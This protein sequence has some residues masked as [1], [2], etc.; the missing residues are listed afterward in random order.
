MNDIYSHLSEQQIPYTEYT[1]PAVFSV[2]ES[3]V[4][5]GHIPGGKTKNLFLRNKKKTKYYLVA[6]EGHKQADLKKLAKLLGE[7]N[8]SFASPDRLMEF[9]GVTPGS[10]TLLGL[11]HDVEKAVTVILDED[12]LKHEHIQCHPLKNT[13][14]LVFTKADLERFLTA[15]GNEY[16]KIFL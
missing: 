5:C 9:L 2:E 4:H 16:K 6:I 1:H 14:T 13:A 8:L 15:R 11:I 3:D 7:Q 12:L 10:V